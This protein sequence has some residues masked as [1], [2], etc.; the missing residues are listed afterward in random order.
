MG[1]GKHTGTPAANTASRKKGNTPGSQRGGPDDERT[2]H[3]K[4]DGRC[5]FSGLGRTVLGGVLPAQ[6]GG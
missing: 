6:E 3:W 5:D 4:I 2:C 1:N